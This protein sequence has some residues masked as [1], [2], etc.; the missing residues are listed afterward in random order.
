MSKQRI[1]VANQFN[2]AGVIDFNDYQTQYQQSIA[3]KDAYW[4]GVAC[5]QLDWITPYRKVKDTCYHKDDFHIRWFDGGALN[6]S[7]NCLDRHLE[8]RGDKTAIIWIGDQ[9]GVSSRVSYRELHLR[10]CR[11]ANVLQKLGYKKGDR[12]II[13][14]PMIVDA[15]VAMLACARIGVIHSVV[16]AGFSPESIAGRI[17]DCGATGVI[18]ADVSHRGGKTI[19]LKDNVD[20]ALSHPEC[21]SLVAHTIVINNSAAASDDHVA[22]SDAHVAAANL[23]PKQHWYH[24]LAQDVSDQCPPVALQAGDPLFILYTSGSTG[25]PKGWCMGALATCSMLATP[26]APALTCKRKMSTGALLTW[27]GLRGT[28]M[29]SMA[30]WQMAR[31]RL[32]MREYPT[33]PTAPAFGKNATPT[34]FR[35]STPHRLHCVHSSEMGIAT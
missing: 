27:V 6:V 4:D 16:F 19:S 18:T 32:C 35:S 14:L 21:Q 33:T 5:A 25:K 8:K 30:R 11:F 34:G 1:N 17:I 3:D 29:S 24:E 13:Y 22:P 31:R 28:V 9:P 7:A 26:F 20:Q 2:R 12:I 10:V 23:E 15:A